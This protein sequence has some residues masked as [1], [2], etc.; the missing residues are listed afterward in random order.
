MRNDVLGYVTDTEK[1][2]CLE[3]SLAHFFV[4]LCPDE[5]AEKWEQLVVLDGNASR[6][7]L[8]AGRSGQ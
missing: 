6:G 3:T 2:E 1:A 5:L 7:G 4:R 8:E